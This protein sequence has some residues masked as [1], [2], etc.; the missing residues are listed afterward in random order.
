MTI[1]EA[2]NSAKKKLE[3]AGIEDFVF[4]AKQIIKHI[5][6]LSSMEILNKYSKQLTPFEENNLTAI[7]RQ[8]EI[9]YPLQYIFGEWDFYGRPFYVGPGVLIPRAD[10]ETLI[11]V[12]KEFLK[13]KEDIKI[14]DLC[15]GSGAIGITLAREFPKAHADMLEKYDEAI[16]YIRKNVARNV[17]SNAKVYKG[18]VLKGDLSENEY[19]LIISNPPYITESEMKL[20][21]PEVSFEPKTA[22]L[23]KDDG[24]EFYKAIIENYTK[25]LKAGGMLCFEVG[26]SESEKVQK[27]LIEAGYKDVNTRK[28]AG[29]TERAVF[30]IKKGDEK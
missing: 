18:D 12:A 23:A 6:G 7:L 17:A 25:S 2:Y 28:D 4:E 1:F 8:R 21:S 13:G 3:K 20:T 26:F 19:T 10:T 29:E 22:L 5:T 30:G 15:A 9:R 14:L 11:D 24:L 27:L 16:T